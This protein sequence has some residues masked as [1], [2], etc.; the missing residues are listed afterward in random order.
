MITRMRSGTEQRER[1]ATAPD[2]ARLRPDEWSLA[3]RLALSLAL[4]RRLRFVDEA[5][6]PRGDWAAV[7]RTDPSLLLAELAAAPAGPQPATDA[8]DDWTRLGPAQQ[9]KQCLTLAGR[10]DEW[11]QGLDAAPRVQ[12]LLRQRIA[13]RAGPLLLVLS[14]AFRRVDDPRQAALPR[15]PAWGLESSAAVEPPPRALLARRLRELWLVL[16]RLQAEA[17]AL[18]RET[19]VESLGGGHHEPATGLLLGLLR[20]L[21]HGRAPLNDFGERLIRHYYHERLGFAPRPAGR[22][23]VHLLLRRDPR[24]LQPVRIEA[25]A[26]FQA[27]KTADGRNRFFA[28]EQALELG[29]L[30]VARLLSLRLEHDPLISPEREYGYPSRA[31]AALLAPPEPQQ[32]ALPRAPSWP[33]LGGGSAPD[34]ELGLALSSGLLALAGGERGIELEL[35]LA[36]PGDASALDPAR[37]ALLQEAGVAAAELETSPGLA[38]LCADC[39]QTAEA[40]LLAPRLGRLFALWLCATDERFPTGLR[41][42]LQ[43]HARRVLPLPATATVDDP[44]SL[45]AGQ[46]PLERELVFDRVFRGLWQARLSAAGGWLKLD[47]VQVRRRDAAEGGPAG[48][49]LRLRL[50]PEQPA[51]VPCSAALHGPGW[52]AQPV[53]QL[54]LSGRSRLF[55]L[56]LLQQLRLQELRLAVRVVGLTDL[57][58]FNQLGRLDAGKPFAPFG[59]LPDTA[60]YLM[61]GSPELLTKPLQSLSLKLRW[62]GLPPGGLARHYRAYPQGPWLPE[63]FRVRAAVLSDGQWREAG[64]LALFEGDAAQRQLALGDARLLR[65]HRPQAVTPAQAAALADYGPAS[66]QGFFRLQLLAPAFGHALYPPL[67][68]E[69]LSHNGRGG[70]RLVPR[71]LPQ[72]PYTPVLESLSL[73]YSA[74][75]RIPAVGPQQGDGSQPQLIELGPFGRT[76]LRPPPGESLPAL[77]PLWPGQGQLY[78]G[79]RGPEPDSVLSL[80]FQLDRGLAREALD[81]AAPRL[82]WAAWTDKGWRALEPYRVLQDGTEGLLRTGLLML[83]LP[84]GLTP[85][86]P[87]LEGRAPQGEVPGEALYWLRLSGDARL[88]QLAPLQGLWAQA[89]SARRLAD[90]AEAQ[91]LPAHCVQAAVPAI[92]GLAGLS[93]PLPGFDWRAA[94]DEAALRVRASERLRHRGRAV[95]AWDCERLVLEEFPEVFKLVCLP[96]DAAQALV[97]L[98]VVPA[99]PPGQEV[100]GTEAPRLDAATLAR[101]RHFLAARCPPGLRLLVRNPAYER[102]QVRCRLRLSAGVQAG[103][104]LRLLN[105]SLRDYLS[106]WR[107]GGITARFDWTLRTEELEAHLRAQ[108]GVDAVLGLSLL[109]ITRSDAGVY[110]LHDT[111]R[112]AQG[113][114]QLRPLQRCSLAL[115]TRGHLLE[116]QG[117]DRSSS[118][119]STGLGRLALGASFIIGSGDGNDLP[120][121]AVR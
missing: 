86:C 107:P 99:L 36:G 94:E 47:E 3:E 32:A 61:F 105:Q 76:P 75:E 92:P 60:S 117:E 88:E 87:A 29:Q 64:E 24:R 72:P 2:G 68:T 110:Q 80:L 98:V 44:L 118:P 55:G 84:D 67:L 13:Q 45:L 54:L 15:H 39:L 97:T 17:A 70:W 42:A 113:R 73:S 104:R 35:R 119:R 66:R 102:I 77:L 23:R 81:Q 43:T 40:E 109:H 58:L 10:L 14:A 108:D 100:D 114:P 120:A 74:A 101:I 91:P 116:L 90:A 37:R 85:G 83:D 89:I 4:A 50:R 63:R 5:G 20:L 115:P 26:L 46:A 41:R 6:S 28:A 82:Q 69:V 27:G 7:L 95:N 12:A 25:G 96:A 49:Q 59:P 112:A 33:V 111:A 38:A 51:I 56:G 9:W 57:R 52:P 121:E 11:L 79:L 93:Q 103:E 78:I 34:A 30:Q 22:D 16:G 8:P 71:E 1:G 21:D 53:L 19:L 62:A 65:L 31:R 106:P 48:L 18:A